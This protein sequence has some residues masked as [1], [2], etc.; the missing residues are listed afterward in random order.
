MDEVREQRLLRLFDGA[1]DVPADER[2]AWI[3][4]ACADDAELL[5]RLRG[6]LAADADDL[7][8]LHRAVR[9]SAAAFERERAGAGRRLGA[10]RLIEEIG[11][12][13]MGTVFLAERADDEYRQRAAVK[14]IRGFPDPDRLERLRTE[15]QILAELRHPAICTLLDGGTTADGEPWLAM[16]H[17]D[18]VPIDAWCAERGLSQMQRIDLLLRVI[19]AVEFAHEHLV[20]HRDIKPANVLVTRSGE[21]KLLDFGIARLTEPGAADDGQTR[22]RYYTPDYSSP[23]QVEGRAIST[24]SDVFSLGR[25]IETVLTAGDRPLARE[26]AAIVDR[27]TAERPADRYAGADALAADLERWRDGRPVEALRG[28]AI[29]RAWRFVTHH[30]AGVA[31][32][33]L[34]LLLSAVMLWWIVVESERARLEAARAEQTLSFLTELLESARPES[35]GGDEVTV[36][37]VL[38]RGGAQLAVTRAEPALQASFASTLASVWLALDRYSRAVE[39]YA[40]AV[41]AAERAGDPDAALQARGKMLV[42]GARAGT[43]DEL[44]GDAALVRAAAEDRPDLDPALRAELLNDWAVWAAEAGRADEARRVLLDVIDVRERLGTPL[45]LAA[46]ELNLAIVENERGDATAALVLAERSLA[47]KR[48]RLSSDHPSL[49]LGLHNVAVFARSAGEYARVGE[50]LDELLARRI[51]LFGE[52]N[53]VLARDF[54]ER[55]N[56]VHDAGDFLRA[57]ELY[58]RALELD[59]KTETRPE[60]YLL[61]NNLAAAHQDRG[62]LAQAEPPLREAL[63][64]R[65][66]RFGPDHPAS[67]RARHNLAALL[68]ERGQLDEAS[69]LA[70]RA[71]EAR[72]RVLG[73]DHVDTL[74]SRL[75]RSWIGWVGRPDDSVRRGEVEALI[76]AVLDTAPARSAAAFRA[77]ARRAELLRRTGDHAAARSEYLELAEDYRRALGADHPR[78]AMLALEVARLDLIEGRSTAAE[79][80]IEQAG[81]RLRAALAPEAPSL[82][83]L[84]CLVDRPAL[85]CP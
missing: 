33:G 23:E 38:E 51:R 14:L 45:D 19:R 71:A 81:P 2:D 56:A 22:T 13:G 55:A 16:E 61:L 20:I 83:L 60:R 84:D 28:R 68:L 77:R 66:A 82:A 52:D 31:V 72:G 75:L 50:V 41:A 73:G 47:R 36:I 34:V 1:L 17:I 15:R 67:L 76:Q 3:R 59:A 62:A 25:L 79:R 78:A 46:S 32:T 43:L 53:P 37:E 24:R 11:S 42:A 18:G 29:Y 58:T 48:G 8:P 40:T 10:W 74:R 70:D 44:A 26:P 7:D 4:R 54:N 27:A 65:E 80:R 21:P 39:L 6:L 63:R 5:E 49:L 9:E 69:A 12:G 64:L 35:T 30:R 57:I 85:D